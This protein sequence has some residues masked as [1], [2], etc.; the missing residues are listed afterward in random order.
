MAKKKTPEETF[1][2]NNQK[3][4]IQKFY[5]MTT[6]KTEPVRVETSKVETC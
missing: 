5:K 3:A 2:I 6:S 1:F 4:G